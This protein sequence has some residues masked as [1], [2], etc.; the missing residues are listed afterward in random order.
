[1]AEML[2]WLNLSP[3]AHQTL[4]TENKKTK[5]TVGNTTP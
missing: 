3:K 4:A 1:M 2:Q 5:I